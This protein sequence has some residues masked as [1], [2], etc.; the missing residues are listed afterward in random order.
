MNHK[1][2][3]CI[4]TT[5]KNR[6]WKHYNETYLYKTL[7]ALEKTHPNFS[8][9]LGYDH[10]DPMWKGNEIE[11][12]RF[13]INAVCNVPVQWIE[14]KHKKG[15]VVAIWNDLAELAFNDGCEYVMCMGDDIDIPKSD[16]WLNR[17]KKALGPNLGIAGGDSGNPALP[18]TQFLLHKSH[19]DLFGYIFHPKLE[20]WFCDN[21]ILWLYGA[22]KKNSPRYHYFDDIK[23]F[24]HGGEPRYTPNVRDG[25]LAMAL[26]KRD[27]KKLPKNK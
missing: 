6:D 15:N 2:A 11:N 17:L 22:D 25:V 12:N 3:I 26:A 24:N 7:R 4:P 18:M 21:Y 10:D 13:G 23:M 16:G 27:I 14:M 5:T 9:Y 20:N 1:I 8:V 19:W